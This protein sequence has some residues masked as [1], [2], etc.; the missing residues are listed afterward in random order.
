LKDNNFTE[1]K[2]AELLATRLQLMTQID[3]YVGVY[4]SKS[5]IKK[6][7]L[8][9]DEEG[10]ER[11]Q[12]EIAE[13]QAEEPPMPNGVEAQQA[14]GMAPQPVAGVPPVA[15]DLNQAFNTNFTK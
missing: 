4:F 12:A 10:I 11:M 3:P 14:P 5:W 7:V 13:E 2:E 9:F 8:Q 1:M 6:H 15:S